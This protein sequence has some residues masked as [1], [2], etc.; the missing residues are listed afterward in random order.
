[1]VLLLEGKGL[2]ESKSKVTVSLRSSTF[3]NLGYSSPDASNFSFAKLLRTMESS[4]VSTSPCLFK[5]SITYK[6]SPSEN[7]K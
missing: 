1:M 6:A 3:E 4:D 7:P 2:N 5:E